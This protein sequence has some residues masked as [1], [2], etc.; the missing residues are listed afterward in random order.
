MPFDTD[1]QSALGKEDRSQK[2]SIDEHV[3]PL[4][5]IINSKADLYTTSSCS[6]RTV[7]IRIPDSGRKN[8]SEWLYVSHEKADETKIRTVFTNPPEDEVWFRYEPFILHVAVK[9]INSA[10]RLLKTVQSLGIKRSGII[11]ISEEK[12][13]LEIIGSER[14]DTIVSKSNQLLVSEDY[15]NLLISK[16]NKKWEQNM[17]TINRLHDAIN[18]MC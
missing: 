15:L 9:E 18:N 2:G 7:L 11:A 13:M 1:K 6:G 14:I 17:E 5:S 4:C 12:I 8:E 16:A 3:V 10:A